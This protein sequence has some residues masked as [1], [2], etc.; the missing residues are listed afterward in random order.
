MPSRAHDLVRPD[1]LVTDPAAA[2]SSYLDLFGNRCSRYCETE[3]LGDVAWQHFA[4][5]PA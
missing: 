2:L 5:V 1:Q 4:S 3:L